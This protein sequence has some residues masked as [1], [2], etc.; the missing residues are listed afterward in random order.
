VVP[1]P[2]L[3]G[4]PAE[5]PASLLLFDLG[6]VTLLG[7]AALRLQLELPRRC[8]ADVPPTPVGTPVPLSR[9]S[10]IFTF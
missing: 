4:E 3:P 9:P 5:L 6:R 7:S 2:D 1:D 10:S 8:R